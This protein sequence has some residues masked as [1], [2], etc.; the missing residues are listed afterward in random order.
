M[1]NGENNLKNNLPINEARN[2]FPSFCNPN[3]LHT[4]KEAIS[5]N[6]PTELV[7]QDPF[8]SK[9]SEIDEGLSKLN[10]KS[11]PNSEV[12]RKEQLS[13]VINEELKAARVCHAQGSKN[14]ATLQSDS[15]GKQGKKV[16]QQQRT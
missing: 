8:L 16:K 6:S 13:H 4:N 3:L 1:G 12:T 11:T 9:L 15:T 2:E 10:V 5:S 14:Q 7:H